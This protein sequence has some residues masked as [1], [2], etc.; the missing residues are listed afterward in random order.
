MKTK[1]FV[2]TIL[3][4]IGALTVQAQRGERPD[5]KVQAKTSA[6]TWQKEFSLSDE[7][8][9]K[10]YDLLIKSSEDRTKK[11]AE[12][13]ASGDREGMREAFTKLQADTDKGLKAIFTDAQWVMYE[14]W[15]K[16]NPPRQ[17]GRRGGN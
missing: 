13:R 9:T 2:F 11:M 7:Q 16:D 1:H 12:L 17:R 14:K 4:F 6:D 8:R 5:P 15:K 10:V 3:F